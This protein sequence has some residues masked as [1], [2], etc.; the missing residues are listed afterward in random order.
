MARRLEPLAITLDIVLPGMDG[1]EVLKQL[2]AD[3]ATRDVPVIIVSMLDNRELGLALGA[4]DYFVKPVDTERLTVRLDELL[5]HTV[6]TRPRVL[7]IDDDRA[8]HDLVDHYLDAEHYA[9]DHAF[10]GQEGIS[11]VHECPP[12]LI[13]LDLMMEGMDGFEV[14]T[15]LRA[16]EATARIPIVVLTAKE[17]SRADRERLHGKIEGLVK[18][19]ERVSRRLT[20]VIRDLVRRSEETRDHA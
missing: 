14:A 5:P 16:D 10:S 19:G 3:P 1:W 18:K 15:S 12:D 17:M 4:V 6:P 7:L 8:L 20:S 2:K 13:L 11:R 9:V